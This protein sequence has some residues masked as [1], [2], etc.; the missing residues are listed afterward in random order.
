MQ[1]KIYALIAEGKGERVIIDILLDNNLLIF[2]RDELLD[3]SVI[4][5]RS[6]KTF[7]AKYLNFKFEQ[8]LHIFRI[9]DSD[10]ENFNIKHKNTV[11]TN[12]LTKPEIEMLI[13]IDLGLYNEYQKVK[14]NLKPSVFLKS[15]IDY[16]KGEK[17]W[18]SYYQND[19]EKLIRNIKEYHRVRPIKNQMSILDI[20]K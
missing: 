8:E 19:V 12:I 4:T 11:V 14:K 15:K 18:T 5:A 9:L 16:H 10:N 3:R 7:E 2:G 17:F 13:I 20:M 1:N 6:E